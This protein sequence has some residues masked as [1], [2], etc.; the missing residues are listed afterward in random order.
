MQLVAAA[1]S[2][3]AQD[4]VAQQ[5]S[6]QELQAL[7]ESLGQSG[8]RSRE[9]EGQL[10]NLNRVRTLHGSVLVLRR[11]VLHIH[12]IYAVI[13]YICCVMKAVSEREAEAR[14]AQ[15]HSSRL[16]GEL[17]RLRQ[18]IHEKCSQE[19]RLRQQLGEKEERTK[20]AIVMAKQKISQLTSK[21]SDWKN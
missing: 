20:K 10:E 3:P 9:L 2:T 17:T 13:A 6:A 15:E 14:S 21:N 7:R 11:F 12:H 5:A 16:Q 8:N 18:E 4:Q 19:E 1:A